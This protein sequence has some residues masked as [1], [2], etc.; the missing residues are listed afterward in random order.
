MALYHLDSLCAGFDDSGWGGFLR[1]WDWSLRSANH[2]ETTR[3]NYLLAALQL[4]RYLRSA[5]SGFAGSAAAL[6]PTAIKKR[7][8][9]AFQAWM[10]ETRKATTALNKHKSLQQFFKWL[11]GED[12]IESSPMARVAKPKTE[13]K[14]I[15]VMRDW[16]TKKL[17]DFVRQRKDF[18]V[19][20]DEAL[21]RLYHHTG[22]RLSEIGNL[23]LTDVD[24]N[25]SRSACTVRARRTACAVRSENLACVERLSAGA[26]EAALR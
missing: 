19:I 3:Y 20:R 14:L 16:E 23:M 6:D 22:A 5:E 21:I 25:T 12:E 17:L 13:E 8:V 26:G 11:V 4:A 1:D 15:P 2:P 9:E 7:H 18:S 24:M 10:L